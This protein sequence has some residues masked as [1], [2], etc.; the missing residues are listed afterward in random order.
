M[1][2]YQDLIRLDLGRLGRVG[3]DPRHVEASMRC[4]FGTL[5]HLGGAVW[6]RAVQEAVGEVETMGPEM[7]EALAQSWG[8]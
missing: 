1:N 8:L 7:S 3:M 5:D 2:R 6:T 4:V